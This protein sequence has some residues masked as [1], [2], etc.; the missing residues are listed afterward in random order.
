M[1]LDLSFGLAVPIPS[2]GV[3]SYDAICWPVGR[4]DGVV[5]FLYGGLWSLDADF[6]VD[7]RADVD[8][9]YHLCG[10]DGAVGAEGVVEGD[11]AAAE[12]LVVHPHEACLG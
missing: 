12:D 1:V 2:H 3:S 10:Y 11:G 7:V 5:E 9:V 8:G 4:V 6:V